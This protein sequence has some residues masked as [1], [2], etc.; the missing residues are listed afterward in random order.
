MAV[1]RRTPASGIRALLP[2]LAAMLA[3]VGPG[4]AQVEQSPRDGWQR[5][6]D[7][8]AAL[9]VQ[10]GDRI[11]DIGAGTGYLAFRLSRAVGPDGRVVAVDISRRSLRR[12]A[13]A[14]A[15]A[16]LANID[17]LVGEPDDPRLEASSVDG[18]VILNAYHEMRDYGAMLA[19]IRRALR[20]GGRLV[21][22]DNPPGDTAQSRE[23][24]AA[25]HDIAIG[26][27]ERDLLDA[28]FRV[29]HRDSAFVDTT[30]GG[31]KREN[32]LLVAVPVP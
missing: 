5:V 16:G 22:V 7:I 17:T 32:W 20:P 4:H 9:E 13:D 23:R 24:Q 8:V 19:G 10:P 27:V 30:A 14:A 12:L 29:V 3:V 18:A 1:Q 31:R 28:G 25:R 11:A 2:A 6:A 15:V 26:I 21:I